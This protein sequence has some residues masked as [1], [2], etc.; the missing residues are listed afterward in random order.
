[1]YFEYYESN[2]Y[3]LNK[4]NSFVLAIIGFY[5]DMKKEEKNLRR[6]KKKTIPYVRIKTCVG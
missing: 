1:M 5:Y 3:H 2:H 6:K 4:A